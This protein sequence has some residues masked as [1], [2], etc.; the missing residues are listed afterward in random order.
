MPRQ[1]A[2][3]IAILGA[4]AVVENALAQLLQGEGY[5]TRV[6]KTSP[7]R[8]AVAEELP[9]GGVDLVIL[10]PSLSPSECEDFL[11]AR[12]RQTTPQRTPAPSPLPVIVLSTPTKEALSLLEVEQAARSMAWPTTSERLV[13]EIEDLLLE[14][15]FPAHRE[16]PPQK[17][18]RGIHR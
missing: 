5:A 4:N 14:A 16:E 18:G 13:A 10:A 17:K 2:T 9:L 8:E 12:R 7:L 1:E 3:T 6:L 15:R 11:A